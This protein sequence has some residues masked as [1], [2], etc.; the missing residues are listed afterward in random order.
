MLFPRLCRERPA[1]RKPLDLLNPWAL[2]E[3]FEQ[4]AG[5]PPL[6]VREAARAVYAEV[7]AALAPLEGAH[8]EGGWRKELAGAQW[9][10]YI[11]LRL[12]PGAMTR[13]QVEVSRGRPLVVCLGAMTRDLGEP[14]GLRADRYGDGC[15]RVFP[16]STDR[17]RPG[18]RFSC[19]SCDRTARRRRALSEAKAWRAGRLYVPICDESTGE[20]LGMGW[21]GVCRCGQD[22]I[23]P[24]RHV[25]RCD[26]CRRHHA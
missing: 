5:G 26:S 13:M 22:F 18:F 9:L 8:L 14:F 12:D 7:H 3:L 17:R 20:W 4:N 16:S 23:D 21:W 11:A 25:S 15:G 19:A 24:K 1:V 2:L 10:S 6:E